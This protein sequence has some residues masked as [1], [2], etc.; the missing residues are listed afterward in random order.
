MAPKLPDISDVPQKYSDCCLSISQIL[1]DQ[2][3]SLVLLPTTLL[4]I[5]SGT[6]LLEALLQKHHPE[7]NVE[8]VEVR[9]ASNLVQYLF[10]DALNTVSG[11]WDLSNRAL[12]AGAWM[13]V[14]PREPKLIQ[15]YLEHRS[16]GIVKLVMWLGPVVDWKDYEAI[17]SQAQQEQRWSRVNVRNGADAG[18]VAYEMMAWMTRNDSIS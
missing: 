15:Q 5:G 10:T 3:Y 16:N 14:Y 11:T 4:S 13:F 9:S 6:G 7:L 8:G 18:L 17:F 2:V 12:E 1:L